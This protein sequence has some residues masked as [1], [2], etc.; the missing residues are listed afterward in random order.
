MSELA[1]VLAILAVM[2]VIVGTYLVVTGWRE[3]R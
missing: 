2:A 1:T 3:R